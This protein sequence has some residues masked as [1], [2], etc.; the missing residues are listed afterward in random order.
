M[1]WFNRSVLKKDK[2]ENRVIEFTPTKFDL[3]TPLQALEYMEER[4]SGSDFLMNPVIQ[5]QTGVEQ[6]QK[7]NIDTIAEGLALDKIKEIQED[8]YKA[9]YELGLDEGRNKAYQ[10]KMDELSEKINNFNS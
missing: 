10:E 9:G 1:P 3:G 7:E 6:L 8:S 2:A 4:K 5:V